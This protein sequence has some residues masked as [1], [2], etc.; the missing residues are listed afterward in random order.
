LAKIKVISKC[1][2]FDG[3]SITFKAPCDCTAVDGLNVYY[4]E[5][6]QSFSFRD[7]HGNNLAGLDDL[8][9]E[10][11]YIKAILDT[12]RGYAF[13]QNA[14]TNSYIENNF[15]NNFYLKDETLT[16]ATKT[17]Y[18]LG[19]SATPNTI[20]QKLAMPYGYYGF[21]ITV[22]L[23]D[24]TP[25]PGV[26][27]NGLQDFEGNAPETDENGRYTT[28]VFTE[29]T[30]TVTINKHVGIVDG[31]FTVNAASDYVF[32]PNVITVQTDSSPRLINTSGEYRIVTSSPVDLCALGGGG[33]GGQSYDWS[34]GGGGGGGGYIE[35]L[36]D[37][38]LPSPLL[39]VSIGGGGGGTTT[40][41]DEN[42]AVILSA[43]GGKN[44]GTGTGGAGNGAGGIGATWNTIAATAGGAA[45]GAVFN[46]ESLGIKFGGGGGGGGVGMRNSYGAGGASFGGRGGWGDSSTENSSGSLAPGY[47][48]T[49]YGGGGGGGSADGT[50]PGG[51]GYQGFVYARVRY[52]Q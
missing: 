42:D 10:G 26:V 35:N 3:M 25:V 17:M 34:R 39:K 50:W 23:P 13:L 41:K 29:A 33:N 8:F 31:T 18:G 46:E 52:A 20:F 12:G 43:A 37:A 47:A 32:A 38:M 40:I 48:A 14:D 21:D 49:G 4:N 51:K 6:S 7:S 28:A 30:A 16:D 1:E 44:G 2:L 45:V 15:K 36:I 9:A 5:Y 19:V 11:A 24:G 22:Q 27:L